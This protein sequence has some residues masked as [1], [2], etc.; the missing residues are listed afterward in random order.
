MKNL[1]KS[2]YKQA[3]IQISIKTYQTE[4]LFLNK[5]LNK[6]LIIVFCYFFQ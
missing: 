2:N 4:M 3:F 5:S 1:E 6:Q